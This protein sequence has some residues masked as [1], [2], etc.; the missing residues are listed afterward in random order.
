MTVEEFGGDDAAAAVTF[1]RLIIVIA[2]SS[3]FSLLGHG[4][5]VLN[6][7]HSQSDHSSKMYVAGRAVEHGTCGTWS[8]ISMPAPLKKMDLYDDGYYDDRFLLLPPAINSIACSNNT[9]SA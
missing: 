6:G 8:K 1:E 2:S 7:N 9:T 5:H 3:S 4:Y